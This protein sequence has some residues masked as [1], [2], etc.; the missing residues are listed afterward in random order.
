MSSMSAPRR[1][2]NFLYY[3]KGCPPPAGIQTSGR[4]EFGGG[5]SQ[6]ATDRPSGQANYSPARL[7]SLRPPDPRQTPSWGCRRLT[8]D[9]GHPEP[10]EEGLTRGAMWGTARLGTFAG[11]GLILGAYGTAIA[12]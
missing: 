4:K 2:S 1:D 11:K 9:M 3:F 8:V 7:A 6:G 12:V 10:G 5:P